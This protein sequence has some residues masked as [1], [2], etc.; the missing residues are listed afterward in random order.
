MT[1]VT[2]W[3]DLPQLIDSEGGFVRWQ[4]RELLPLTGTT[5]AMRRVVAGIQKQL[6][7]QRIGHLPP[8][9]PCNGTAEILLYNQD[10]PNLG[11]ALHLARQLAEGQTPENTS[12]NDQVKVLDKLLSMYRVRPSTSDNSTA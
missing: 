3:D 6:A 11:T 12:T 5:K 2:A 1:T 9:L 10:K 7:A 8:A 4:L